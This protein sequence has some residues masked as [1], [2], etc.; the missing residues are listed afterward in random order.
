MNA[1][2]MDMIDIS[3]DRI[4][5]A[6]VA[7]LLSAMVVAEQAGE[8]TS[9]DDLMKDTIY[10]NAGRWR[11]EETALEDDWRSSEDVDSTFGY[12]SAD[13]S[14]WQRDRSRYSSDQPDSE[15]LE[16]GYRLFKIEI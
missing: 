12:N 4:L 15:V 8:F 6:L 14:D 13:S 7:L 2:N 5:I 1:L 16:P 3:R 9:Y 11:S 10:G